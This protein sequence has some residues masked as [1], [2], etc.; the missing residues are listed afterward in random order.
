MTNNQ[1]NIL[2][3]IDLRFTLPLA[4]LI[5][6]ILKNHGNKSESHYNNSP[7]FNFFI[8]SKSDEL[9][10]IKHYIKVHLIPVISNSGK[11]CFHY[12][13]IENCR[14]YNEFLSRSSHMLRNVK[15]YLTEA[16]LRGSKRQALFLIKPENFLPV[17]NHPLTY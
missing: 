13:E 2:L 12:H 10:Q 15:S 17:S 11:F 7:E 5:N 4:V 6:S 14:L 1:I 8:Y 16:I 3:C 9:P